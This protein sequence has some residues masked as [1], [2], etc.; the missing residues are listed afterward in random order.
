ME[1]YDLREATMAGSLGSDVSAGTYHGDVLG[2]EDE[3]AGL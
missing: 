1:T 3:E 2:M